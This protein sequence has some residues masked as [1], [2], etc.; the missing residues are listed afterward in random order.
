MRIYS[1]LGMMSVIIG[2]LGWGATMS[3]LNEFDPFVEQIAKFFSLL[4]EPSRLKIV[5][6][7][8]REER[9][10][11]EIVALT[12]LT[13][14]NVSRQLNLML[15]AGVLARRKEGNQAFFTVS[16]ETLIDVCRDVCIRLASKMETDADVAK[17]AKKPFLLG[18]TMK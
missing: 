18:M 11:S 8:C 7:I 1:F 14:T 13:Q 10:V 15:N 17:A 12:G 16:D 6:V 9:N 5:H 3:T 4:S 2:N